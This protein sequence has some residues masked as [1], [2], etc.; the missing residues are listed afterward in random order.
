MV[1]IL[2]AACHHREFIKHIFLLCLIQIIIKGYVDF[3]L[4]QIFWYLLFYLLLGLLAIF[5]ANLSLSKITFAA[6][7]LGRQFAHF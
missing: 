1:F 3:K 6:M 7:L 4:C 5:D 2:Q